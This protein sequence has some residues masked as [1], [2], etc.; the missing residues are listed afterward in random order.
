MVTRW[1][2]TDEKV[3]AARSVLIEL[4][5]LLGEYRDEDGEGHIFTGC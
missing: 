1:D 3:K 2:Y 4:I 5:R